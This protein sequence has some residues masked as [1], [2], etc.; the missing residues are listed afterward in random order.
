MAPMMT[1]KVALVTGGSSGIGQATAL[2]F[3]REGARTVVAARRTSPGE[4][5]VQ[6]I[7][8]GGGEAIF[9]KT[10]VSKPSEVQNLVARC[11]ETYGRLDYACNNAGIEGTAMPTIDYQEEDWNAVVDINLKG[12]W[13][14][15][16]YEIPPMLSLIHI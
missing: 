3:A 13:L 6:I 1:G 15:L 7:K 9:V 10:D 4:H 12:T 14:C 16:K 8:D 2:R 11:L 5:T